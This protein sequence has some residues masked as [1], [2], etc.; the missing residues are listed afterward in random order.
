LL[1]YRCVNMDR[2]PEWIMPT[3]PSFVLYL[4]GGGGGGMREIVNKEIR[5]YDV[6]VHVA[7]V[8]CCPTDAIF[9]RNQGYASFSPAV[10][11]IV[12]I[13]GLESCGIVARRDQLV[14]NAVEA[15]VIC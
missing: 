3:V 14:P 7:S 11:G 12:I 5:A 15:V 1:A 4:G 2:I 6:D 9:E 8:S 13:D 10:L